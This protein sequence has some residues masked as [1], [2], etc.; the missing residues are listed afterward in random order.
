M[1]FN[2]SSFFLEIINFLILIWILQR[3]FY[4][5]IRDMIARR[6]ELIDHSLGQAEQM[7]KEAEQLKKIIR[8]ANINGNKKNKRR[9]RICIS[10]WKRKETK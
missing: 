7:R 10:N 8:I 1:E 9:S 3:L 2:L 5:P 6:K 4:R